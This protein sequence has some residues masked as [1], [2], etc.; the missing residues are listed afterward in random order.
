MQ[1]LRQHLTAF[2]AASGHFTVHLQVLIL[3]RKQRSKRWKLKIISPSNAALCIGEVCKS[4]TFV[5]HIF[6]VSNIVEIG[7]HNYVD[8]TVKWTG[9]CFWLTRCIIYLSLSSTNLNKID[10]VRT[11]QLSFLQGLFGPREIHSWIYQDHKDPTRM[12]ARTK[13]PYHYHLLRT[14]QYTRLS[15]MKPYNTFGH[16]T[17]V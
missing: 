9:N 4:M 14:K 5:L 2:V 3:V 8:T 6:F 12:L 17:V 15:K 13:L 10:E 1:T 7:Q 11:L 16:S